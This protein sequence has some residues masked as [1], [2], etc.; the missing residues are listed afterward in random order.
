MNTEIP[1]YKQ[2]AT[3]LENSILAG[4]F[5]P[6]YRIPSVRELAAQY[7]VNPNTAQRAVWELKQEGLLISSRSKGTLVTDDVELI[8]R[9]RQKRCKELT[10]FFLQR[11]KML[12]YSHEQIQAMSLQL[13]CDEG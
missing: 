3:Q 10:H 9:F 4:T 8:C 6:G 13:I 12:G 5:L 2:I 11:M 1:L 7:Q